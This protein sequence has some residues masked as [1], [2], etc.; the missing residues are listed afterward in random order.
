MNINSSSRI[1][2][3]LLNDI[4]STIGFILKSNDQNKLYIHDMQLNTPT[5]YMP[6]KK[7]KLR[8]AFYPLLIVSL[9]QILL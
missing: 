5:S 4:Y 1:V 8:G 3:V 6:Y 9:H 7:T 2:S